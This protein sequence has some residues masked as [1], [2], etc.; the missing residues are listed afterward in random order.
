MKKLYARF[1]IIWLGLAVLW[2]GLA[3]NPGCDQIRNANQVVTK[4]DSHGHSWLGDAIKS[5]PSII[6][7]PVNPVA[8]GH[9]VGAIVIYVGTLL[10]VRKVVAIRKA[11]T[12]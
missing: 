3:F 11:R 8:W 4:E 12:P 9:A 7:D 6:A 1:S 2:L 10:G 5:I